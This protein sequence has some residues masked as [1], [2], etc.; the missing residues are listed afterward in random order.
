MKRRIAVVSVGRSDYGLYFPVL[1][2]IEA[3]DE[4][5]LLLIASAGHLSSLH[6]NTLEETKK[7]G[8][9][10]AESVRMLLADDS[11]E[12]V[13][14]SAGL[15]VYGFAGAYQRLRPDIVLLLGDRIEMLAAAVAALPMQIL[16]GHIHGGEL[17]QGAID[18][19]AR[20]AITK[21]SHLHFAAAAPYARRIEQMGEEPERVFL[22]GSPAVDSVKLEPVISKEELEKEFDLDLSKTL[23]VTYHPVTLDVQPVKESI[24]SLLAALEKFNCG[25]IV[26][27]P[28]ADAGFAT[29]IENLRLFAQKNSHVRL[30]TNLGRRKYLSLQ[31]YVAAMVGNSSS[32]ILEASVLRV[33]V[34]NIGDRQQGRLRPRNVIDTP[35]EQGAIEAAIQRALSPD[36]RSGLAN[37]KNPYG[38]GD[39]SKK[40]VEILKS[41]PLDGTALKKR[42]RDLAWTASTPGTAS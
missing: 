42:F 41:V 29:I 39:A 28:N 22:T 6:G 38:N 25:M 33:P 32:G 37:M 27:Y 15:G 26:T 11:R 3:D 23:L 4:C 34:V 40:I 18:D 35:A 10:I 14:M 7:D 30:V 16:V 17:T 9:A 8:I 5:E 12:A 19:S 2:A 24:E 13:A 21:L 1:R 20:H 31:R 36:F